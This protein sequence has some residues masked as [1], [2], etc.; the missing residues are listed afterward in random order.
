MP[1]IL[2]AE[3]EI[4]FIRLIMQATYLSMSNNTGYSISE[5]HVIYKLYSISITL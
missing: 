2:R 4:G 3:Q 5:K 1:W